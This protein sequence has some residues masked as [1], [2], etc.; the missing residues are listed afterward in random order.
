ML[1]VIIIEPPATP[2]ECFGVIVPDLPGCHSA[3]ETIEEAK[4]N[5]QEAIADW[6]QLSS[7]DGQPIPAPRSIEYHAHNPKYQHCHFD[8]VEIKDQRSEI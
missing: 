7:E 8:V 3:G 2:G 4:L 5:V 6:I 1:Y